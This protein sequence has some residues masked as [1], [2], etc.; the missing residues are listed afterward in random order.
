MYVDT[1]LLS[2]DT[3]GAG[4][5]WYMLTLSYSQL[6]LVFSFGMCVNMERGVLTVGYTFI[7]G[8]R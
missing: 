4:C 1:E 7:S 3:G 5:H 6:T 2:T 8:L